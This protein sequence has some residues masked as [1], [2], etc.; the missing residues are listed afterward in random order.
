MKNPTPPPRN[1][2]LNIHTNYFCSYLQ[3]AFYI[4]TILLITVFTH[5]HELPGLINVLFSSEVLDTFFY[6]LVVAHPCVIQLQHN[7]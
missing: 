4:V 6:A 5:L 1:P 7:S 3:V 2:I